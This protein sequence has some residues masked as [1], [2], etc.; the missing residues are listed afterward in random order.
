MFIVRCFHF[1]HL[2]NGL[3]R[4]VNDKCEEIAREVNYIVF[5]ISSNTRCAGIQCLQLHDIL[6]L[7]IRQEGIHNDGCPHC[8]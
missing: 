2:P 4:L 5:V 1:S 3:C 8:I 6:P 7:P